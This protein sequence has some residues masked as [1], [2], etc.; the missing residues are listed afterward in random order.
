M[1][2]KET[3]FWDLAK[4]DGCS[5]IVIV[6]ILVGGVVIIVVAVCEALSK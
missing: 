2:N 4:N 6:S 3:N 5:A 1:S